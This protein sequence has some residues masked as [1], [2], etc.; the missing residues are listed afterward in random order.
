[1]CSD[2]I[3]TATPALDH[4]SNSNLFTYCNYAK[5]TPTNP[6]CVQRL[7]LHMQPVQITT[8][9]PTCVQRLYLQMRSDDNNSNWCSLG[10]FT[11]WSDQRVIPTC[12]HRWT[13]DGMWSAQ[14]TTATP[15]SGHKGTPEWWMRQFALSHS[16]VWGV[17]F[18]TIILVACVGCHLHWLQTNNQCQNTMYHLDVSQE[19][20][21]LDYPVT[22]TGFQFFL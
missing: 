2:Q 21:A 4:T 12:V 7:Y 5:S 16:L 17:I 8:A 20:A 15:T 14:I 10:V 13:A 6:T 11:M 1:M 19:G 18:F 9:I 22:D 3:I